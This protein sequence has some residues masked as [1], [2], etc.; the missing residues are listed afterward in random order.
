MTRE[1]L[2]NLM[3]RLAIPL[4]LLAL[5]CLDL[6]FRKTYGYVGDADWRAE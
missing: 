3:S 4:W 1:K 6:L 2:K 5:L